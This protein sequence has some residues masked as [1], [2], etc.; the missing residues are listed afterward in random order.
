MAYAD[1]TRQPLHSRSGPDTY[2]STTNVGE[3]F[4]GVVT[5]LGWSLCGPG[6][7]VGIRDSYARV[8]ALPRKE[9]RVPD[10]VEDRLISVFYGRGALNVNF[11]C[12]MGARL[13]GSAPDAV[14][15]Q[16]LGELPPGVPARSTLRRLPAVALKMPAT[17]ATVRRDVLRRTAPVKPWWQQWV[18]RLDT[19][20]LPAARAALAEARSRFTEMLRVQAAGLFIGVQTVYDRL[21]ALVQSAGPAPEVAEALMGGQGSHAE[22]RLIGDLWALGRGAMSLDG[23]LA[24]HGYHGPDEGEVSAR[25]W[26]EDP[27][28]VLRLA[29]QYAALDSGADPGE[30]A[31][32]R[33]AARREAERALLAALPAHRRPGAR[34]VL[35]AALSRIPLR[36]VAKAAFLQALDVARGAARRI[37]THLADEGVLDDPE[38][39]FCFTADEL[40]GA[41]PRDA[42]G[43]AAERRAQRAE[44]QSLAL[45]AHWRGNPEPV[46]QAPA[47]PAAG[48]RTGVRGIGAA[49]GVAEGIVRVVHDAAFTEVEPG[50]I[51]VC[52]TTDPSWASVLFLSG[53]LVVDVGGPLSHAAVVAREIGVPCVV[54]TGDGT[55]ALATGDRVRVDGGAGTV[56][57]LDRAAVLTAHEPKGG[58]S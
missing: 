18:S 6:V 28:P 34:I 21:D 41:L 9:V 46:R 26:R 44:F 23:F 11:F 35:R 39:V 14:A 30:A 29:E 25:V 1:L 17:Q 5:P 49:G 58:A 31:V 12:R 45:P 54:G 57:V 15:R 10:R 38:D 37:G 7:E 24:E 20:D 27:A 2:W 55:R 36:G 8:G 51:L 47:G 32:R 40:A 3:A 50:D 33:A 43:I 56:E 13:P 4:P 48:L 22:S 52:A 53:A 42:A 16:F 19:L